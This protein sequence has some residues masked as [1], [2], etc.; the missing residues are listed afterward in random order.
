MD[1]LMVF[2]RIMELAFEAISAT[3]GIFIATALWKGKNA[4][5]SSK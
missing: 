1:V 2:F 4:A 5:K 3:C